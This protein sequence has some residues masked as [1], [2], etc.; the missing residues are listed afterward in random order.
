M[1][2]V[3]GEIEDLEIWIARTKAAC[4]LVSFH[5]RHDFVGNQQI[6]AQ[7][8]R[9][10]RE[11]FAAASRYRQRQALVREATAHELAD[12]DFIVHAQDIET[13]GGLH[14]TIRGASTRGGVPSLERRRRGFR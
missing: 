6:E 14:D 3:S 8:I 10:E 13:A 7:R 1:I 11:S 2:G 12:A 5:S 9:R 4:Q